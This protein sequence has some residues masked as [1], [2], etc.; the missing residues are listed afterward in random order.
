M[1]NSNIKT[2][3]LNKSLSIVCVV[4]NEKDSLKKF[5]NEVLDASKDFKKVNIFLIFDSVDKD[6]SKDLAKKISKKDTRVNFLEFNES[7][8][9][10]ETLLFG[11]SAALKTQADF[12]LDINAGYR[13][14]PSDLEKFYSA[15]ST[16]Y[17]CFF[18]SRFTF[19][20]SMSA[21]SIKRKI[22]SLGGTYIANLLLGTDLT[23]MT[24]GFQ[25]YRK[26]V[27]KDLLD[28]RFLSK[29]HFINTEIKFYCKNFKTI[30]IP[31]SYKTPAPS[32][33]LY[34]LMDAFICLLRIFCIRFSIKNK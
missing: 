20:G 1:K 31:I 28:R 13:H 7:K 2:Y 21:P 30:E 22:Y 4:A 14:L 25:L 18:G 12:V 32:I 24:S 27:V 19:G 16:D 3:I 33:S 34:A 26:N 11:Y 23:D 10:V 5:V 15:I 17:D 6:G 8:N 29:Y 9:V